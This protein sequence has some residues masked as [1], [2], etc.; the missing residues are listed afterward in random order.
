MG[1]IKL[2][3][4]FKRG[5]TCKGFE[6]R[7]SRLD[8]GAQPEIIRASSQIRDVLDNLVYEFTCVIRDDGRTVVLESIQPEDTALFVPG[9]MYMSDIELELSTG[10]IVT[11]ITVTYKV[12]A[13]Y[14][15]E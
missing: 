1:D 7:M 6:F 2:E 10:R 15:H 9:E 8:G 4:C 11:P 12:G 5:D 14:T 13:D 3:R